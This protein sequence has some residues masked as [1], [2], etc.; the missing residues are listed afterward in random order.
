MTLHR[1]YFIIGI[2]WLCL[3]AFYCYQYILRVIPNLIMSELFTQ[4]N[5]GATEFGAFAGIYYIG[6][7]TLHIPIGL[8]LSR[9]EAKIILP[10]CIILASSGLIP[11]A[12][13]NSWEYVL[14][15]RLLTGIGSSAAIIGV[16]QIFRIIFPQHFT[17]MLGIT[18]CFALITAVYSSKPLTQILQT[19]GI[20]EV[21][22]ILLIISVVLAVLT[23]FVL[24]KSK[25]TTSQE[26]VLTEIKS[27]IVNYKL[28]LASI[29]AGLMIGPLEG[30]ADAWCTAF[31][32]TVYGISKEIAS[33][34]GASILT[35]MC[36][37]CI[38]LPYFADKYNLHYG[39]TIISGV[40]MIFG[41]IYLLSGIGNA[42]TLNMT[43]LIIGLFCAYQVITVSKIATYVPPNLSGMAAAVANMIAMGFG[44][45]FHAII[46]SNM[47]RLWDGAMADGIKVYHRSAYIESIT[48]I[49][50]AIVIAVIGFTLI[51][52]KESISIRKQ[53]AA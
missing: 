7:I 11:I 51:V 24:P 19:F 34:I 40:G 32:Y 50:V 49:P 16:L 22:N 35:G 12:Y 27:V 47:D 36:V 17:R 5:V 29:L 9:L 18:V 8:L 33:G 31:I 14:I 48:I 38:V 6:Y 15:G 21:I 4:F 46:G 13:A 28:L 10:L 52:F 53:K 42:F 37:G 26:G 23:Y 1:N 20:N 44:A 30:F 39:V 2:T 43:C 45:I 25:V 41:F 3:T